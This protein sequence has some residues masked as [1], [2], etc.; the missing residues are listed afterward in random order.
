M[1]WE[2]VM[3]VPGGVAVFTADEMPEPTTMQGVRT[4]TFQVNGKPC[5]VYPGDA[6]VVVRKMG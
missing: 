1:A 5:A 3:Y 4:V 6:P 2:I